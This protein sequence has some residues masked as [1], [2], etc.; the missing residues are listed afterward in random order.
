[1]SIGIVI[2]LAGFCPNENAEI[3]MA[4]ERAS[5]EAGF[6]MLI[7]DTNEFAERGD[8][9]RHMLRRK[10]SAVDGDPDRQPARVR[11]VHS[12]DRVRRRAVR[13]PQSR[14]P[15]RRAE[16]LRRRGGGHALRGRASDR[17]YGH[18]RIG[19]V[20]GQTVDRRS[21]RLQGMRE[22]L[23]AGGLRA[24]SRLIVPCARDNDGVFEA[25]VA[26]L[27]RPARPTAL[28]VWPSTAAIAVLAAAKHCGLAVPAD[29]LDHLVQRLGGHAVPRPADDDRAHAARRDGAPSASRTCSR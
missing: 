19:Y 18:E 16:R 23:R 2:N 12:R 17:G 29:P 6:V 20:A 21:Q 3:M 22:A 28:C 5:A 8:V 25:T 27:R 1:M 9:Y 24:A 13:R 26:L 7:A 10:R 14:R 15:H 11:R 4:A